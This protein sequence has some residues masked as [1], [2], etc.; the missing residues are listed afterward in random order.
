MCAEFGL[1]QNSTCVT[2]SG[3]ELLPK[4]R[5][6]RNGDSDVLITGLCAPSD[7]CLRRSASNFYAGDAGFK[8][9]PEHRMSWLKFIVLFLRPCRQSPVKNITE[10]DRLV[11]HPR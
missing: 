9:R 5:N 8:S 3:K 2:P 7:L 11:S 4:S 6:V 1:V 10:N